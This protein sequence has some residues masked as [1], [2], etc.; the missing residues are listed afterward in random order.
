MSSARYVR[1][2]IQPVPREKSVY[3]ILGENLTQ[4]F[5]NSLFLSKNSIVFF[6]RKKWIFENNLLIFE[7]RKN[8]NPKPENR[9]AR[10]YVAW[11]P[12]YKYI[13][14]MSHRIWLFFNLISM[15]SRQFLFYFPKLQYITK[16]R[17]IYRFRVTFLSSAARPRA[18]WEGWPKSLDPFLDSGKDGA[19]K[20][21]FKMETDLNVFSPYFPGNTQKDRS[22]N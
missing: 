15:S 19:R 17:A 12:E 11:L 18:F 10:N 9:A 6:G 2:P 20:F 3:S 13:E 21:R 4:I 7:S 5:R 22:W 8:P 1:R 14:N 16:Q